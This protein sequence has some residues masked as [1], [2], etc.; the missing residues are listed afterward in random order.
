MKDLEGV[1]VLK[2]PALQSILIKLR[3]KSTPT[4]TFR[5]NLRY[6]GY[7]MTYEIVTRECSSKEIDVST[8]L[9]PAKGLELDNR[10]LQII[11]MR[12]GEPLT[13]GG[14]RLLDELDSNRTIGVVDAKRLEG[15]GRDMEIEV[16]SFKVPEL[17]GD[18]VVIVYDP[19]VATAST[20]VKVFKMFKKNAGKLIVCSILSTEFGV[21][22]LLKEFPGIRIYTLSVDPVLNEKGFIVPGLGDCGDRAFGEYQ[23]D[24]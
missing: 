21:R 7:L 2:S 8:V 16:S 1:H 20:L 15:D 3:D 12:A 14:A 6:A 17:G 13:E 9:G 18:E 10:I 24:S 11:I 23:N 22:R 5:Q 19:M 4:T